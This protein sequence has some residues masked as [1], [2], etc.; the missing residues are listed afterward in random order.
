ML[1]NI[2]LIYYFFLLFISFILLKYLPNK[3]KVEINDRKPF[4]AA[5]LF[6]S[7]SVILALLAIILLLDWLFFISALL[8]L[9]GIA[10]YSAMLFKW[11]KAT[12]K[13]RMKSETIWIMIILLLWILTFVLF[14]LH[15]IN[16]F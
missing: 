15:F 11:L 9:T 12:Q 14:V 8:A 13:N 1:E 5:I 2:S 10:Q 6:M 7:L 16:L 4:T 3:R